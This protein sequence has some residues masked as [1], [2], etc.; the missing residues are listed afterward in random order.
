[1]VLLNNKNIFEV[2]KVPYA[3]KFTALDGK[4]VDFE[5][6]RGKV[7]EEYDFVSIEVEYMKRLE[8]VDRESGGK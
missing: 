2:K 4:A 6:L 7:V 3:L 1:M 8:M 5:Q